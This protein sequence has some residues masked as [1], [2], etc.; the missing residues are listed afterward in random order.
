MKCGSTIAYAERADGTD[1]MVKRSVAGTRTATDTENTQCTQT[2]VKN[3]RR[4][5]EAEEQK[6]E[7]ID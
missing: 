2:V 7:R 5:Q 3:T 1:T 6:H 4:K